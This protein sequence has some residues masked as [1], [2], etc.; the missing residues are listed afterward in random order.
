ME[1]FLLTVEF[2]ALIM[3]LRAVK[4]AFKEA[5]GNLGLF[6]YT[7]AAEVSNDTKGKPHA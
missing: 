6:A 7:D 1:A 4:K 5:N 2:F 3:L